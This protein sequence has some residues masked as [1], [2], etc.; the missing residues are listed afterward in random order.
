MRFQIT[1][2]VK[3]LIIINAAV[4]FIQTFLNLDLS[5]FALRNFY[6]PTFMPWQLLTH[7]F[8][9]ADFMHLFFN[10]FVLFMFG[11]MLERV[12]GPNRFLAFYLICGFGA[13][14]IYMGV[15]YYEIRQLE[16]AKLM[17]LNDPSPSTYI[18][19]VRQFSP[20]PYL[21]GVPQQLEYQF[22]S[23]PDNP[24]L[25]DAAENVV[26]QIYNA[27]LNGP[28]VGASGAI[29]GVLMGFGMLF[30]NTVLMLIFPPIPIKAKYMV[31]ILAIVALFAGVRKVPG[32]NIAHFAH[33]GGMVCAFLV[34]KYWRTKNDRF[35]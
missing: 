10:M 27:V 21:Y 29:Y 20:E 32:D 4:L 12:W 19:F 8:M 16:E 9:H 30:P 18:N 35:Y 22:E 11:P 2:V 5:M 25:I 14:L 7:M 1:P 23:Q 6:A 13:A 24:N 31:A 28:M 26:I 33:L 3:Y 17:F 34:I 15:N